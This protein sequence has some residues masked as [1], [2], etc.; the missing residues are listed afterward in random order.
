VI[1]SPDNTKTKY[2]FRINQFCSNNEAE[3]EA[4]ITSLEILLELGAKSIEIKGDSELVL[5]QLT[6]EYKCVKEGLILYLTLANTLL[7]RFIHVEIKHVPRMENQEANDLAQAASRYKVSK[8]QEPEPIEIRNKRSLKESL[9]KKL[10]T[11][12]FGGMEAS[13]RQLQGTN[14]VEILVVNNLTD[15]DWRKPIVNYLEN[16]DGTTCRKIKYK[17]LSYVI[18][19]NKLFKK[20]PEGVLLKCLRETE[21]YLAVSNTHNGTCGTHQAGH[22]MKWL[23]FRQG[24][25]WPTMLKDCIEFAKGC[26]G[27]QEHAG[28]Q[29]V[30]ASE[31]HS[32]VKPWPFRGWALDVI[33]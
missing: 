15:N 1:V 14:L 3:Y 2:K 22:K 18:L 28:I 20:T 33:G 4:L 6:K 5:R 32:I 29:R 25:Y 11:P 12:K 13:N 21:A 27:C 24:V 7:K 30:P 23:L 16:P 10:S 17:A 9:P 31:L 8:D 26:Q 19:G